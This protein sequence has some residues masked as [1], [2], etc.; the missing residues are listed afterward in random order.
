MTADKD[1]IRVTD[2]P[3]APGSDLIPDLMDCHLH[4][5]AFN[6]TVNGIGVYNSDGYPAESGVNPEETD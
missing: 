5:E 3:V 6:L 2:S 4:L 1:E